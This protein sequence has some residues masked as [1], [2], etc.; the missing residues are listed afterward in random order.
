MGPAA[1]YE[2]R[3]RA[4][5]ARRERGWINLRANG[6]REGALEVLVEYV[7]ADAPLA[8]PRPV[9]VIYGGAPAPLA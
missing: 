5:L 7:G 6:V 8:E 2:H 1:G 3:W 4:V 9:A